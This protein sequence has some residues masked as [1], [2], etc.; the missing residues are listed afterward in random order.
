M[1]AKF[2]VRSVVVNQE[3]PQETIEFYAVTTQPFD[4][5]G[6]SEDNSFSKWTPS[7]ELK[8]TITNPALLGTIQPGEK[9]YLDFTKAEA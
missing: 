7:G 4:A 3:Y 1:R 8:M 5:D 2:Q 9:Y 6:N